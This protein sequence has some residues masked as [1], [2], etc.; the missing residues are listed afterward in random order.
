MTTTT[1]SLSTIAQTSLDRLETLAGFL[2]HMLCQ[3][4]KLADDAGTLCQGETK[5][6]ADRAAASIVVAQDFRAQIESE[7]VKIRTA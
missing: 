1:S 6:R 2:E 4:F 3:A 7:L 5:D